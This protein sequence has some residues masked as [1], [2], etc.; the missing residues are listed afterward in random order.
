MLTKPT[1]SEQDC[2]D[3]VICVLIGYIWL[4]CERSASMLLGDLETGYIAT[5]VSES[6]GERL[7]K[8]SLQKGVPVN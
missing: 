8:A 3:S 7:M 5:P 2:M 6:T 4:A 1:K